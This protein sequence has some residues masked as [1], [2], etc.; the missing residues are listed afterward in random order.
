MGVPAARARV[1]RLRQW[2]IMFLVDDD[3]VAFL[4]VPVCQVLC[5]SGRVTN[6]AQRCRRMLKPK[7]VICVKENVS[8]QGFVV[9]REDSSLTRSDVHF[10]QV[11]ARAGCTLLHEQLQQQFPTELFKVMMYALR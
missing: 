8:E 1:T 11:F 5:S 2:V 6:T 3:L 7:G 4:Q 10:K 9:D